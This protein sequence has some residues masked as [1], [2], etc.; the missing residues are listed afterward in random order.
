MSGTQPLVSIV[1]P[2]LNGH[3]YI[4]T[5]IQSCLAQTYERFEL[6]VVDGGSSDG[7]LDTVRACNDPRIRIVNQEANADRLPGALNHGFAEAQGSLF[8]WTQDDDYYEPEAIAVMVQALE[9]EPE[10]GFVY[11]GYWHVDEA[12]RVLKAAEIGEPGE[13][14]VRNSI[15]NCFLYR[16]EVA[17]KVGAYDPAFF[18]A[19]DSH[20]WARVLLVTGIKRLPGSYFNHRRH[21]GSLTVRDYG[22]YRAMRVAARARRQVLRISWREYHRQRA[23]AFIQEAFAAYAD[24][25]WRRVRRC[26]LRGVASDPSWLINRGVLSIGLKSILPNRLS[27]R[28]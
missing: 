25:A 11:T 26:L 28:L 10:I 13:L 14:Y 19:E 1:L 15:G 20:Y 8:T 4:A 24:G 18:M 5:S 7:T 9:S 3:R 22:S 12:G 17:E 23:N 6:I 16:R 2:T 21:Q 27:E